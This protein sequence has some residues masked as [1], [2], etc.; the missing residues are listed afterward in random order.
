MLQVTNAATRKATECG[1]A[2]SIV[3]VIHFDM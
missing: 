3:P 1:G 2:I